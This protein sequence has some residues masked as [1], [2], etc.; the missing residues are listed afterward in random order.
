MSY[1]SRNGFRLHNRICR[2]SRLQGGREEGNTSN[3]KRDI[4]TSKAKVVTVGHLLWSLLNSLCC[5]FLSR[6]SRS[7]GDVLKVVWVAVVLFKKTVTYTALLKI[8]HEHVRE[9]CTS[10]VG[11]TNIF[12]CFRCVFACV[13]VRIKR[14]WVRW[15]GVRHRPASARMTSSPP[16]C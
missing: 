4:R 8:A 6:F 3:C 16:G 1:L 7:L 15:R 9:E 5:L 2:Q 11:V 14:I 10:F 12:E 13:G